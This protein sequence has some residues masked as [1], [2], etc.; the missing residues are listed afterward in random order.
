V[1]LFPSSYSQFTSHLSLKLKQSLQAEQRLSPKAN[2]EWD[3][4]ASALCHE[5]KN[6]KLYQRNVKGQVKLYTARAV[7]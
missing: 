5:L 2:R 3:Q 1:N 4:A 7:G 6:I